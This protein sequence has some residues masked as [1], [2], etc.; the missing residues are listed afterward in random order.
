[1]GWDR[2][3]SSRFDIRFVLCGLPFSST[4]RFVFP[5]A[6]IDSV[7]RDIVYAIHSTWP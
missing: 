5:V 1:M 2:E 7:V 3:E 6:R 4:D